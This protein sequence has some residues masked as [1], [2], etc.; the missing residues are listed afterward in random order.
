VENKK[1]HHDEIL[2]EDV[3]LMS[4]D[5]IYEWIVGMRSSLSMT[6]QF[7][8]TV[9]GREA[10]G[11]SLKAERRMAELVAIMEQCLRDRGVK[12]KYEINYSIEQMKEAKYWIAR[13]V[14]LRRLEDDPND[15]Y[16]HFLIGQCYR[17]ERNY[18]S[19]LKHLEAAA[20]MEHNEPDIYSAFAATF[21]AMGQPEE[22]LEADKKARALGISELEFN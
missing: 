1:Q 13:N 3:P 8:D 11:R 10:M 16:A 19:S 7:M 9:A 12:G 6:I 14:L 18:E 15:W 5:E 17:A 2:N 20:R 4:S 21:R 22:A